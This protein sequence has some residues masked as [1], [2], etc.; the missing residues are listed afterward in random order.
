M[1][2]REGDIVTGVQNKVQSSVANVSPAGILARQHR[3]MAERGELRRETINSGPED[4]RGLATLPGRI[5][6]G[7]CPLNLGSY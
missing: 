7:D 5:A 4:R 1:M 6:A 3:K 2:R